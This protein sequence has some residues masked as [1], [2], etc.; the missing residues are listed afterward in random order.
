MKNKWLEDKNSSF[1]TIIH[2]LFLNDGMIIFS[3]KLS[4][5]RKFQPNNHQA[6][7]IF[8]RTVYKPKL[9]Q[10]Y[11]MP[12]LGNCC[13]TAVEFLLS[14][15]YISR[16]M[17]CI[18]IFRLIELYEYLA[19]SSIQWIWLGIFVIARFKLSLKKELL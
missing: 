2:Q 14:C 15:F 7:T 5:D 17:F 1:S 12:P 8:D 16:V 19:F 9:V 6:V 11:W 4:D 13:I 18:V 10:L 3:I